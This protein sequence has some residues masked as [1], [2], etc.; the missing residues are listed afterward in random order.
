MALLLLIPRKF[1]VPCMQ[2][3]SWNRRSVNRRTP[4]PHSTLWR[5]I[6]NVADLMS[7]EGKGNWSRDWS[8]VTASL[9]GPS[10]G[11]RSSWSWTRWLAQAVRWLAHQQLHTGSRRSSP[12]RLQACNRFVQRYRITVQAKLKH[13]ATVKY[14][15]WGT[16]KVWRAYEIC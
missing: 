16:W 4:S 5:K 15:Q 14:F 2:C 6:R 8:S 11:G 13:F 10:P 1:C 3:N 7:R 9:P 12:R